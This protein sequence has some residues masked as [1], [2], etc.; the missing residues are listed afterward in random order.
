MAT[1]CFFSKLSLFVFLFLKLNLNQPGSLTLL[2]AREFSSTR[3]FMIMGLF[4]V[5]IFIFLMTI[6]LEV[7]FF[8]KNLVCF[9]KWS[10]LKMVTFPSARG[11]N[12]PAIPP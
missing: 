9:Q 7:F 12:G 1:Q 3:K 5:T 8:E 2:S 11:E 10:R 6:S 4:T